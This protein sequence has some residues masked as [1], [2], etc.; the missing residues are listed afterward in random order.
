[1]RTYH[2]SFVTG[3]TG[4][5]GT[6]VVSSLLRSTDE[7]IYVLVR[8]EDEEAATH[9]LKSFWYEKKDLYSRIGSRIHP[10]AGDFTQPDLGLSLPRPLFL[11][12][13]ALKKA[14]LAHNRKTSPH[15]HHHGPGHENRRNG[16]GEHTALSA[17]FHQKE[18]EN[19]PLY[20]FRA[21][22]PVPFPAIIP[23]PCQAAL[24]TLTRPDK[25]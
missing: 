12:M 6:E 9:R 21:V 14:G 10:L 17:R 11:P 4:F 7:I 15:P 16:T 8:A 13:P 5:L 24:Y 25:I 19:R 3:A 18:T 20:P 23:H 1:M 2:G 22:C